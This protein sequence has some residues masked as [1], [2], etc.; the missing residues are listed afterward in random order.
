MIPRTIPVLRRRL[1]EMA[2]WLRQTHPQLC[3]FADELHGIAEETKRRPYT[4]AA[5]PRARRLTEQLKADIRAYAEAH[6]NAHHEFEI[7]RKFGVAGGRVTDA[8]R[9]KRGEAP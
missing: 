1:F 4:R 6:P 5:K 2:G 9:G 8:I 3:Y 7:A